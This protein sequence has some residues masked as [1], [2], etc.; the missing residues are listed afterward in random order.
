MPL[1]K[2]E[3]QEKYDKAVIQGM[4]VA[5]AKFQ[6]TFS[7]TEPLEVLDMIEAEV[8]K[9]IFNKDP[10]VTANNLGRRELMDFILNSCNDKKLQKNIEQMK[11]MCN[12]EKKNV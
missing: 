6:R 10:F 5:C 8:P 12:K 3:Q 11:K 7:G 9:K 2:Q 1:S 4:V